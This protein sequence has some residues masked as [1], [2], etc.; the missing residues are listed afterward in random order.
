MCCPFFGTGPDLHLLPHHNSGLAL[1]RFL[2][3]L[4]FPTEF[5]S[6]FPGMLI[7]R[8]GPQ[9]RDKGTNLQLTLLVRPKMGNL[10]RAHSSTSD[11]NTNA[12]P[13]CFADTFLSESKINCYN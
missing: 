6:H 13:E 12:N 2:R 3:Y 7:P 5:A 1:G 10:S 8:F 9:N 11:C 4:F